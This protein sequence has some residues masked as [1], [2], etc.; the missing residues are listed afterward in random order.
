MRRRPDIHFSE[1]ELAEFRGAAAIALAMSS[2]IADAITQ[3]EREDDDAVAQAERIGENLG[4]LSLSVVGATSMIQLAA[5]LQGTSE[6][7]D[8]YDEMVL[9]KFSELTE[10]LRPPPSSAAD[11]PG[12]IVGRTCNCDC[13]CDGRYP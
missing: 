5:V 1:V 13:D 4:T 6:T 11:E 9:L 8:A 2:V 10:Q 7:A 3:A 12:S